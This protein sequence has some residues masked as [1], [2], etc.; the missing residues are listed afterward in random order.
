VA[1]E[2]FSLDIHEGEFVTVVGPSGCGKSTFLNVVA[3]L[4]VPA[5]GEVTVYGEPVTGPGVDRAVVFQ[6]Y[7]LLPWRTVEANVRFGLAM[8]KRIDSTTAAKVAHYI[9]LVGLT[10][11]EKA[12]P[13]ELS[14]GDAAAGRSGCLEP[15]PGQ[16]RTLTGYGAVVVDSIAE[17]RGRDVVFT[18]VSTPP[19]WSRCCSVRAGC[20]TT[21]PRSPRRSWTARGGL[22]DPARPARR[23]LRDRAQARER[24]GRR[25]ARRLGRGELT[26]RDCRPGERCRR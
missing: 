6:D 16:G 17:L 4:T 5:A 21:R 19:T 18:M 24:R 20:W 14:G 13:R 25:R 2:D 1:L 10:G 9:E 11:F 22:C 26:V 8:Q 12:Y 23:G 7:A 3:G 15:D